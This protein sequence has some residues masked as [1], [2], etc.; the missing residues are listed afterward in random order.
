MA[1]A[2]WKGAIAFGLVNVPVDLYPG[3]RDS[4]LD[5]DWIDKRDMAPVGYQRINKSTGKPVEMADI[6]KGYEY[7]K[8]NYVILTDDDF[9]DANPKAT[10]TVEILAFV[11]RE[12]ILPQYFERPY[13]L[14][15]G[16]RGEKGYALLRE[17]L[18]RAGKVGVAQVVIRSKQ[19]LA[20]LMPIGDMLELITMRYADEVLGAEEFDLP[21]LK[22]AK[23]SDKEVELAERL[24]E[25][26]TEDWEPERYRDTYRDD[27][28]KRIE[29]LATEG[30][31]QLVKQPAREGEEGGG[32]Q[33]IDLMAA[34]K[35][36]LERKDAKAT[37]GKAAKA[38]PAEPRT[39]TKRAAT[40]KTRSARSVKTATRKRA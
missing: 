10:Q 20:V 33:I 7:E 27:L 21:S 1:R 23:V 9:K 13:R 17:T 25:D 11:D 4:D 8:G 15:P 18:K 12:A 5:F 36:S 38:R 19:H 37:G 16:K 35:R 30:R 6:V 40:A 28:M 32:A 29:T 39:A 2:V 24:V 26:M 34:L 22:E 14:V 3:S 31:T